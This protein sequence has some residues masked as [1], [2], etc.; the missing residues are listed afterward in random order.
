M[1]SYREQGQ[2]RSRKRTTVLVPLSADEREG[3]A[4]RGG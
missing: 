3:V 1:S 2:D 4:I